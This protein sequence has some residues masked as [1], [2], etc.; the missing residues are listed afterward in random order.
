MKIVEMKRKEKKSKSMMWHN[1]RS[2]I[3]H[4]IKIRIELYYFIIIDFIYVYFLMAKIYIKI[5]NGL[6]TK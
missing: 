5:N 2:V 4:V 6:T 1:D 3:R